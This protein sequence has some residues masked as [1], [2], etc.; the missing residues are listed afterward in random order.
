MSPITSRC[1]LDLMCPPRAATTK[2]PGAA[3][4]TWEPSSSVP[5]RLQANEKP[6]RVGAVGRAVVGCLVRPQSLSVADRRMTMQ[7]RVAHWRRIN[8][9]RRHRTQCDCNDFRLEYAHHQLRKTREVSTFE[10]EPPIAAFRLKHRRSPR[11]GTI[12]VSNEGSRI[13][14]SPM[15]ESSLRINSGRSMRNWDT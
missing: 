11:R 1:A 3:G 7:W 8:L 6:P 9:P 14:A 15:R 12:G 2:S 4:K 5:A 13:H 10:Q